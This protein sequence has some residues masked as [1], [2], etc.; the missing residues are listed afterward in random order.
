MAGS[1]VEEYTKKLEENIEQAR[2]SQKA[3][4]ELNLPIDAR[5]QIRSGYQPSELIGGDIFNVFAYDD[6]VIFYLAD[7]A[8]H[9]IPSALLSTY[10]KACLDNWV[11]YHRMTSTSEIIETLGKTLREQTI[12][13]ENLLTIFVGRFDLVTRTLLYTSAGHPFPLIFSGGTF[14]SPDKRAL[15]PA[16]SPDIPLATFHEKEMRLAKDAK[17]FLYSDGLIEWLKEDGHIFG[18]K[19][20]MEKMNEAGL[21]ISAVNQIFEKSSSFPDRDDVSF[22]LLDTSKDYTREYYIG[23]Q[24]IAI[25]V[26][27]FNRFIETRYPRWMAFRICVCFSEVVANAIEHGNKGDKTKKLIV[28][29]KCRK[30][31]LVF[32]IMDEGKLKDYPFFRDRKVPPPEAVRG[33][34]LIMINK[35]A[36][37]VKTNIIS[38]GLTCVFLAKNFKLL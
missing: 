29:V 19:G 35:F 32:S 27:E 11:S 12:F 30:K 28:H 34:G 17:L 33:R 13:R 36:S 14:I 15:H 1:L 38:G 9:G 3:L 2:E 7:I 37:K 23:L 5:I 16:I 8:G 4:M 26:D 18:T 22:M 20:L 6:F 24:E 10:V 21:T 31:K 25:P